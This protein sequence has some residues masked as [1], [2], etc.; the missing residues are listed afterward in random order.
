MNPVFEDAIDVYAVA[1]PG[2][3]KRS[4]VEMRNG[5]FRLSRRDAACYS[6][7]IHSGGGWGR[8][9]LI[10]GRHSLLFYQPSPFTGSFT[11]NEG[12]AFDALYLWSEAQ[13]SP[14]QV[15]VQ[16]REPDAAMV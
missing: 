9:M 13:D 12:C 2:T 3:L 16:W 4:H 6:I 5:L 14:V 11:L 10:D 1:E 8:L 15:S 7:E